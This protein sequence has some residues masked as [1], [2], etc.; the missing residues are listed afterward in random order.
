LWEEFGFSELAAKL[1]KFDAS[2]DFEQRAAEAK[3]AKEVEKEEETES[4]RN[5]SGSRSKS[6]RCGWRFAQRNCSP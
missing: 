2:L 4:R 6:R 5:G 3:G 1:S